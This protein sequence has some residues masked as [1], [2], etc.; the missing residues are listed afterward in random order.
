MEGCQM[1]PILL[2]QEQIKAA[3]Q[4]Y[5][6]PLYLY[7]LNKISHQFAT[8]SEYLPSNFTIHY[9][10]KANSNLTI[11]RKLAQLGSSA[12]VS[13]LG[14]L[15][16]ALKVGFSPEQIVFTGPGKTVQELSAAVDVG[17]GLIV[18]ESVNE[19]RRLNKLAQQHGIQQDVLIRINPIY[20]TSQSCEIRQESGWSD[21]SQC[22]LEP[23]ATIQLISQKASKFG[24][25]E[26][27]M[28][29]AITA[30]RDLAH[31]NLK[32]IHIYTESNV[33]NCQDLLAS[34][35]NTINIANRLREQGHP[36]FL[37]DFGGGIGIPYND[38]DDPFNMSQFGRDLRGSS[39][40][41]LTIITA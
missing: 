11:C 8:L 26:E 27:R 39:T 25:D 33:L 16:A 36:I 18:L 38:I 15:R 37:I 30:I 14:E 28:T 10:M 17:C 32:G 22:G 19:A 34:W 31:L 35:Q 3:S 21:A 2:S 1:K 12:D 20:R 4:K 13:S 5:G 6:T 9:A 23:K 29:E 40:I 41:Q 7:N 24:V